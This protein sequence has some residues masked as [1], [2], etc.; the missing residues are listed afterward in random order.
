MRVA[1]SKPGANMPEGAPLTLL[2]FGLSLVGWCYF[3][4]HVLPHLLSA[5]DR[6][7]QAYPTQVLG[8]LLAIRSAGDARNLPL[9]G[10]C[11]ALLVQLLEAQTLILDKDAAAPMEKLWGAT[12]IF[13]R[14]LPA[15]ASPSDQRNM[16]RCVHAMWA[17]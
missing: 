7:A 15:E 5:C 4:S 1:G 11:V 14:L 10:G 16:R 6:C 2:D 12:R 17:V 13:Q 3:D 8:A 9:A